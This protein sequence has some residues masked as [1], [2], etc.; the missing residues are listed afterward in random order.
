MLIEAAGPAILAATS[1]TTLLLL[2]VLI[3]VSYASLAWLPL[4]A[5]PAAPEPSAR[6]LSACDGWLRRNAG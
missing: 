2:A 3:V 1:P 4:L 6:R 5:F